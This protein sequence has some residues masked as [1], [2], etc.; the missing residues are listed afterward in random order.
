MG[1]T[2]GLRAWAVAAAVVGLALS[3]AGARAGWVWVEGEKPVRSTMHRHP[4]WYDQVKRELLSGGDL[5]SN[6]SD[7]EPGEA[8]YRVEAP[9]AA[10]YEFWVRANPLNARL[11]YA[12]NDGKLT[13]IDLTRDQQGNT[14]VAADGK[15][16]LRF[17]AWARVGTVRLNKGTNYVRFRM[18]GP[19]SNH[20]YLDC[21]VF[22]TEPFAPNGAMKP[23][24]EAE[25]ARRVAAGNRGWFAFA[26]PADRFAPTSG[27][28]LRFLNEK[29]AGDGGFIGVK[30]GSFVHT[31]TGE[32]VRFWAV[33]GPPGKDRES[34]RREARL[35]AKRGV[36]LVRV[37]HG[38]FDEKGDVKATRCSA[39]SRRS[40]P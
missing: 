4:W 40:K 39:R 12:L 30:G 13:P 37:H 14:N 17:L 9:G 33:N 3:G 36:N 20:G 32:P 16:D 11:A 18:D 22:S 21:F 23:G 34:L 25:Y 10:E 26:P 28:D 29:A 35:L 31:K 15:P 1:A 24:Q 6:F 38:Y 5:I 8:T 27:I 2:R 7:K 19:T